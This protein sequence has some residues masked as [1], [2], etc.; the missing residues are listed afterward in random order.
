M[1]SGRILALLP[2]GSACAGRQY[3]SAAKF[4]LENAGGPF[5]GAGDRRARRGIAM[6]DENEFHRL[7]IQDD[8]T[9]GS[10]NWLG[11]NIAAG[12]DVRD[13]R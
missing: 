7:N 12:N 8:G 5:L 13:E 9:V 6:A 10:L 3:N 11:L 1:E 4:L 2:C